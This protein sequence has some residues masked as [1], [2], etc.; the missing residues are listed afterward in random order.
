MHFV[1]VLFEHRK[2]D[3]VSWAVPGKSSPESPDSPEKTCVS[4]SVQKEAKDL[5]FA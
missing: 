3:S 5:W 1:N 4:V 2:E